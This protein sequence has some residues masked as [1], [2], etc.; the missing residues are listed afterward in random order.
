MDNFISHTNFCYTR[1]ILF[2]WTCL[3]APTIL[4]ESNGE[5]FIQRITDNLG[6]NV[7]N[8]IVNCNGVEDI[9][10]RFIVPVIN[11]LKYTKKT[12]IFFSNDNKAKLI[13][14]LE[15]KVKGISNLKCFHD[16]DTK[17]FCLDNSELTSQTVMSYIR[18]ALDLENVWLAKQIK[19]TYRK[20][21]KVQRL[22]STP[23]LA[24]GE[25]NAS[26]I[27]SDPYKYKWVVSCLAESINS[28]LQVEK[29]HSYTIIAASL[30]GAAIAGAIWELLYFSNKGSLHI[31][32]HMGPRHDLLELPKHQDKINS[33]YC[34]YV[35]DFM[36]GGTEAKIVNSYC[37]FLGGKLRHAFVIGKYIREDNLGRDLRLHSL[38]N[39][40]DCIENL[41]Y[42]LG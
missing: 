13:N 22:S 31:V 2:S 38:V 35:G 14:H 30:R 24:T 3:S 5:Y 26:K 27:L 8:V 10:D 15:R 6:R 17:S 23:L 33:T 9:D 1:I 7:D 20:Y 4:S 34:I 29:P 11:F 32:D 16:G 41:S 28:I 12:F 40:Q 36:I 18:D 21:E 37:N 39:L 42:S 25:F 19:K